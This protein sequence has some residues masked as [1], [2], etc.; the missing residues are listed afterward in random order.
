MTIQSKNQCENSIIIII[1]D[2]D[3][4][5]PK[6]ILPKTKFWV[7]LLIMRANFSAKRPF[8]KMA[9]A[10]MSGYHN[11]NT[12]DMHE[13]NEHTPD[14]HESNEHTPDTHESNKHTPDIR[15][16]NEHTPDTPDIRENEQ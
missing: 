4:Q 2:N 15:E 3:I 7:E 14:T 16:N 1:N 5:P 10:K 13:S 9:F 11:E 6:A 8:D 12:S